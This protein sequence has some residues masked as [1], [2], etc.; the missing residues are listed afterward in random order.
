[1]M[2]NEF[3]ESSLKDKFLKTQSLY[4]RIEDSE[5]PSKD[6]SF[7]SDVR[8]AIKHFE[9]CTSMVRSLAIFSL[10]ETVEDINTSD[11]SF[12]LIDYYLA[13]LELKVI[14]DLRQEHLNKAL[15]PGSEEPRI[16]KTAED[17]RTQKIMRL[18][19]E[20]AFRLKAEH[21]KA[22]LLKGEDGADEEMTRELSLALLG[23]AGY[24]AQENIEMTKMEISVLKG[25]KELKDTKGDFGDRLDFVQESKPR[26]QPFVPGHNLPTMSI[27]EYIEGEI[28][29]G[30]FLQGGTQ[31]AKPPPADEDEAAIEEALMKARLNDEFKDANPKGWGNRKNKG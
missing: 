8:T 2:S 6:A 28:A 23:S 1:M 4:Q 5:L 25:M 12:L 21:L 27:D 18:K 24:K 10:N 14:D 31:P 13:E 20:R 7:Q 11:L 17:I 3:Q 26:F 16:V 22:Q 29:A 9:E 30:N 15:I 19:Q